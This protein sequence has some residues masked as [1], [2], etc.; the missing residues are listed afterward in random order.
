VFASTYEV[1]CCLSMRPHLIPGC[2]TC[3]LS[4]A[5]CKVAVYLCYTTIL[6]YMVQLC[7]V[8]NS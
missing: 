5:P 4:H 3:L 8:T 1:S 7:T 6:Q 2:F